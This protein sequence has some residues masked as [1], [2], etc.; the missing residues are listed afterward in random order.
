M[1]KIAAALALCLLAGACAEDEDEVIELESEVGKADGPAGGTLRKVAGVTQGLQGPADLA[2]DPRVS[3]DLWIVNRDDDS[4]VIVHKATQT[5]G[6]RSEYRKDAY[7]MHFMANP[8]SIAFGAEPTTFGARG[9]FATCGESRNTYNDMAPHNDFMGP[10]LWT[11]DLSIFARKDPYGLG[12]HIDMLHETPLCMGIA[13]E[14]ANV[15]WAV[16]GTVGAIYRYD[17]MRDH[18]I[19]RD[20]HSDGSTAEYARGAIRRVAGVP[21]GVVFDPASKLLYV[22]DS[23]NARIVAMDTRSGREASVL[24]APE[25]L[26]RSVRMSGAVLRDVV[27]ASSRMLDTP[28]GMAMKDGQ[29][30]VAD[31][32]TGRISVFTLTGQRVK[33]FETRLAGALGGLD[34]GPD[35]KLYIVDMVAS[36]VLRLEPR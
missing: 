31:N 12:S 29:L 15:Y 9:T 30:W 10:V 1:R 23:G 6:R 26:V 25:P 34:F 28:S 3:G 17:F 35:G 14:T 20:D 27:P 16:G 32:A 19:G 2:F 8:M 11:S 5:T 33:Y 18:N 24:P 4:A 13:H 36:R 7:A 21:M 22:A